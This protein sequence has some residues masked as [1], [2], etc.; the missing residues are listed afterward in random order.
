MLTEKYKEE[1]SV[2]TSVKCQPCI[3][4]IMPFEPKMNA[5]AIL[6][7]SLKIVANKIKRDLH[8]NY[9]NDVA[10]PVFEKLENIIAHLDYTTH[11]KSVAIYVSPEIEKVYYL[12]IKVNEK[13]M[14]NTSFE[15]RDIVMNKKEDHEFLLLVISGKKEKL[16]AGSGSSLKLIVSNQTAHIER[17]L[18]EPVANFTD[19]QKIKETRL[20]NFLYYIDKQLSHILALYSFPFFVMAS[21]KTMG[22]FENITKHYKN[23]MGFV[24]GNFDNATENELLK[25]LVPQL[26]NWKVIKERH[27]INRLE[28]AKQ[29]LKLVTGIHDVWIQAS[30]K[31]KQ[32][33]V[34]EKDFYCPAFVTEK[35]ETIFSNSSETN[36][37]VTKDA[38]DDIIEK[39]LENGGDVE[40][41]ED[42]KEYNKIALIEQPGND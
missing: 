16:Y 34:V 17:D 33:L 40:F 27:I 31:H 32:L 39:V 35:G 5:E 30:R 11:R 6:K 24:H 28:I 37:M 1:L 36:K 21:K 7:H 42:L 22:Y 41:V 15:I 25:A 12:N 8:D 20:K 14:V 18:P 26:I 29:D 19:A 10:G 2:L 4:V 23:I 9:V 3:S 38:I 13:A